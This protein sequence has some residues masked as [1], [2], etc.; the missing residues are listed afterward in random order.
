MKFSLVPVVISALVAASPAAAQMVSSKDP[1]TLV[2]ALKAKDYLVELGTTGGEPSIRSEIDGL[3]FSIFFENCEDGKN[4]TTVT[5]TTGFTD[6]DSTPERMNEWNQK[7]RF[8][9]AYID[10]EGDPVLKMDVDLDFAGIPR[11]NFSEYVDIWGTQAPKFL[12]FLRAE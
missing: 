7:N 9:R 5:F 2:A 10:S 8:A 3:R 1:Q 4:C 6:I 12:E 11:A